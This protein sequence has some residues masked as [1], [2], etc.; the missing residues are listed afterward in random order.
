MDPMEGAF[1]STFLT[2]HVWVLAGIICTLSWAKV[3][4][5]EGGIVYRVALCLMG[6][7]TG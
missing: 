2:G 5:L 1:C 4:E 3:C 6:V 7:E